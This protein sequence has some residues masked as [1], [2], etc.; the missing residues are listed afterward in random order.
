MCCSLGPAPFSA[1]RRAS[2][3]CKPARHAAMVTMG[4]LTVGRGVDVSRPSETVKVRLTKIR[5]R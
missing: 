5:L 2:R 3:S 4:G 1:T